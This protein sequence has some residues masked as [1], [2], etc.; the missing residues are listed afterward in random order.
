MFI[1]FFFGGLEREKKEALDLILYT[2][3]KENFDLTSH[4]HT[5]HTQHNTHITHTLTIRT[6]YTRTHAHT[7]ARAHT[8]THTNTHTH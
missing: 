8:H 2:H 4:T 5:T 1:F 6:Q 7:H 3:N